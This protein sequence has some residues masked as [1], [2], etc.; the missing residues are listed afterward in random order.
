MKYS[1]FVIFAFNESAYDL[2][3]ISD[4]L[5]LFNMRK[6]LQKWRDKS[7][8]KETY[9]WWFHCRGMMIEIGYKWCFIVFWSKISVILH[10]NLFNSLSTN[11]F[12]IALVE[13]Q[14]EPDYRSKVW[15]RG[16]RSL[17]VHYCWGKPG[18]RHGCSCGTEAFLFLWEF[19]ANWLINS[20]LMCE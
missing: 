20:E 1:S 16:Q 13:L 8:V 12:S 18:G 15:I 11:A 19:I 17:Q 7:V 9:Y 5:N 4:S 6:L 3:E 10:G 14:A 2:A